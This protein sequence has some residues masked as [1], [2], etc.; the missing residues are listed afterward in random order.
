[1]IRCIV[2]HIFRNIR[3]G[4]WRM[5]NEAYNPECMVQT[6]KQEGGYVTIWA[7]NSWYSTGPITTL[8]CRITASEYVDILG[9]Q[10]HPVVHMFP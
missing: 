10:V 7:E 5:P 6:V 2:L 1:M 3:P 9:N 8:H 4:V